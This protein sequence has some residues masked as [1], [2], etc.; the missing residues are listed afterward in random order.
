L[1]SSEIFHF[2]S[3]RNSGSSPWNRL[4][5]LESTESESPNDVRNYFRSNPNKVTIWPQYVNVTYRQTD[6]HADDWPW[7]H[8]AL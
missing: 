1:P 6:G 5:L 4:I 3:A 2:S 8:G 7:Q